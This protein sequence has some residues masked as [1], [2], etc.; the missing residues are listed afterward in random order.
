MDYAKSNPSTVVYVSPESC[1]VPKIVAEYCKCS[2]VLCV[3]MG[4]PTNPEFLSSL[5]VIPTVCLSHSNAFI[6][7]LLFT[8]YFLEDTFS[9][10]LRIEKHNKYYIIIESPTSFLNYNT[11]APFLGVV[12]IL[13]D[14]YYT[15]VML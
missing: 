12:T 6:L 4:C 10:Y 13:L 2:L 14:L 8:I 3:S 15:Y 1:R 11:L 9:I 5:F 7:F